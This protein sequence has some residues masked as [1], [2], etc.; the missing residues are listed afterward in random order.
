VG[1]FLRR[2]TS[3]PDLRVI[4]AKGLERRKED[5]AKKQRAPSESKIG[6]R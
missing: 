1:G 5:G 6:Q 4:Q 2:Q 3:Y